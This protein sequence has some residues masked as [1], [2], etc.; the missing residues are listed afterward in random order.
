MFRKLVITAQSYQVYNIA[1]QNQTIVN[2]TQVIWLLA[3]MNHEH[4]RAHNV[5]KKEKKARTTGAC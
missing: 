1:A 2:E 3:I 4:D 5:G